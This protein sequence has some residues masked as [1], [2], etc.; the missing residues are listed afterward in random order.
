MGKVRGG[1]GGGGGGGGL[2]VEGS[3]LAEE[4]DADFAPLG[5]P[6]PELL[7]RLETGHDGGALPGHHG[8][9]HV[10]GPHD[11]LRLLRS[12]LEGDLQRKTER[13]L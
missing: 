2:P 10:L 4:S 1:G 9:V 7:G 11:N 12:E 13:R 6:D 3:A 5:R 8:R